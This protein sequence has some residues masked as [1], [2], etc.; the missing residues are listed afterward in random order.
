MHRIDAVQGAL[1]FGTFTLG[2]Q[3]KV[4][5]AAARN[6]RRVEATGVPVMRDTQL[7]PIPQLWRLVIF[8]NT[9]T[10]RV[11]AARCHKTS[12]G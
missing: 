2:K 10:S 12:I 7:A 6:P 1:P 11:R 3:R 8:A 9:P 5:R 4:A